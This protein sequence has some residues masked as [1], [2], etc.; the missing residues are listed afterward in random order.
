MSWFKNYASKE[1]FNA[2]V[3]SV[4]TPE[5]PTDQVSIARKVAREVMDSGAVGGPDFTVS[6]SG[7]ANPNHGKTEGWAND[8]I[9]VTVSQK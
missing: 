6:L 9:T 5:P 4:G 8:T 7:H 2:D 1:D 3:V